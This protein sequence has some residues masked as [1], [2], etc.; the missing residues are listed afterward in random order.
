MNFKIGNCQYHTIIQP[1]LKTFPPL[2]HWLRRFLSN[3]LTTRNQLSFLHR[4]IKTLC[5]MERLDVKV[6]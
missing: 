5:K 1:T 6:V 4:F 3:L 2:Y